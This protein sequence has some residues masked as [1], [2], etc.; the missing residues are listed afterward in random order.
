M[1]TINILGT[2]YSVEEQ[3][4]HE[5]PKLK[6][7]VGLC[8]TY[9]KRIIV[10]NSFETDP[11]TVEN[12]E[13]FKQKVLRHEVVHAFLHESGL[14]GNSDWAENE[15]AVDWIAMQGPKI[16]KAWQELKII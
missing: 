7:A 1:K 2:E 5:N 9:S 6:N 16:M 3:K 4:E 12:A 13:A 14:A 10:D 11:M 15:E 8:E